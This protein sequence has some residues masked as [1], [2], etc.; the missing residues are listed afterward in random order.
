MKVAVIGGGSSY[1]PELA[2]GLISRAKGIGLSELSLYDVDDKRLEVVSGFVRR[3]A[4]AGGAD[5]AVSST[6]DLDEA[7]S[8]S[9][10][11]IIQVR[12]GGN[13]ARKKDELLG[14]RH[15]L[16][17]QETTGVG[18]FAKAMRTVPAALEICK[19]IEA[20][21]PDAVVIN[22][23]NPSG[24]VTEA[25]LKNT[26]LNAIGLCNIPVNFHLQLAAGLGAD[27]S[28]IELD[29]VGLNHLSWVRRVLLRGEDVTRE[30]ISWADSP[31]KRAEI[32]ELDYPPRFLKA[33][34]MIPMHYLRYYYMRES[35]LEEQKRSETT[36]AD[37]VM[38]I[39]AG[40]M[41]IY[42]DQCAGEKPEMLGR[43]GGANYSLAA[44]ELME[45]ILF[46]LENVQVLDVLNRGA[47]PGLPDDAVVEGPCRAG[48]QG[49]ELLPARVPEP[50]IAGLI[51]TVKSYE[52]LTI[53]AAL[54]RNYDKALLALAMHP[55]GPDADVA[56]EVLDDIM[57]SSG[58]ALE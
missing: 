56:G 36:R 45:A 27:R 32:S 24:L 21:A 50:V 43:R 2:H 42:A 26:G 30:V 14:W 58:L 25:V 46:N 9:D 40:L 41:E 47:V 15:G 23:T 55:L 52:K 19:R 17:G 16:I 20:A 57:E 35:M 44:I 4:E 37:E 12:V 53:E 39:E 5:L 28:E 1:T 11:I 7:A 31:G 6:L 51:N 54:E 13:L 8:G 34:G 22:F 29:Y 3:M 33:L 18:G 10:F 49:A 38:E 48:K